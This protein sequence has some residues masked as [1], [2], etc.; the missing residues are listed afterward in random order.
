[1]DKL[2]TI[3]RTSCIIDLQSEKCEMFFSKFFFSLIIIRL[4]NGHLHLNLYYT[5]WIN[6]NEDI[7]FHDCIR[8]VFLNAHEPNEWENVFYC[9]SEFPSQ[10]QLMI[11]NNLPSLTFSKL[12]QQNITAEQLYSWSTPI[13]LIEDYQIYLNTNDTSLSNK[14]F[15][16]CT[17]P[18]FGSHCE[19]QLIHYSSHYSS[20]YDLIK[21]FYSSLYHVSPTLTCYKHLQCEHDTILSCLQWTDICDG[22][23][24]CLNDGIDEKDC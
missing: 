21:G 4:I 7:F 19:Y 2:N 22:I 16:N 6:E 1:M 18:R 17:L 13:D 20:F 8:M 24:N 5:G 14:R 23:V 12:K 11:N 3:N 10:F 9:L 15:Y